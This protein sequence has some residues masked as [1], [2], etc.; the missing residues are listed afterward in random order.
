MSILIPIAQAVPQTITREATALC[1]SFSLRKS[2]YSFA[3]I[4][5]PL[6]TQTDLPLPECKR[7]WT[8][9]RRP[10]WRRVS[11]LHVRDWSSELE[12]SDYCLPVELGA[13]EMERVSGTTRSRIVRFC[14]DTP[15]TT[16][17]D[18]YPPALD[19][20]SSIQGVATDLRSLGL[21]IRTE[22]AEGL[23]GILDNV[24]CET[25]SIVETDSSLSKGG[26]IECFVKDASATESEWTAL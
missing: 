14:D 19:T 8:I 16:H 26:E 7:T 23:P 17:T 1:R 2:K 9:K 21:D 3:E 13:D 12:E 4:E 22:K 10:S 6:T 24:G 18:E 5:L 11:A 15:I 25:E 20:N